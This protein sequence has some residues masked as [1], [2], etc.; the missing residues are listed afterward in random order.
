MYMAE[1]T[2]VY[3]IKYRV[4]RLDKKRYLLFP[5]SLV[6]GKDTEAGFQTDR[7]LYSYASTEDDY[8]NK[9]IVDNVFAQDE[10][11]FIYEYEGDE[12]FLG[13]YFFDDHKDTIIYVD[14]NDKDEW[15]SRRD[16]NLNT[17]CNKEE[18]SF[19]MDDTL[20]A[21]V[22][23]EQALKEIAD[24]NDLNEV[25]LLIK[26]YK[27]LLSSFAKNNIEKGV[28]K[29]SV[30]N[31]KV[32][33]VETNQRI[34]KVPKDIKV[35][36]KENKKKSTDQGITYVGL[37]NYLKERIYGHDEE[38]ETIALKL[39]M[40]YTAV[41]GEKVD[42]FLIVGP[43]GTGKT[44][45]IKA[46]S[47]YLGLPFAETNSSNLVPQGIVGTSIED[48]LMELYT[49]AGKDL[50]KAER[51]IIF[52]DEFDKVKEGDGEVKG[53]V[54]NILL[55]FTAGGTFP[56]YKDDI[57]FNTAMLNKVY[58]GVFERIQSRTKQVGF[59]ASIKKIEPLGSEEEIRKK[60]IEKGYFTLEELSR[61]SRVLAYDDLDRETKKRILLNSK[62]SEFA[63]RKSRYKR[64]FDVDLIADMT[65]I[66]AIINSIEEGNTG[67]RSVNNIVARTIDTAEKKLAEL[68][69]K[70]FKKLIVT[71]DTVEDPKKFILK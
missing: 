8:K 51:G 10:L 59:N 11:E 31:G 64:Q 57:T 42:S 48:I 21:V 16:V 37:R 7:T 69:G 25:K 34:I 41:E 6:K 47:T 61:I 54:K 2:L 26:K 55:T 28:T 17:L 65:Y 15:K 38:I 43:T 63:T 9:Y 13:D 40:N 66:D 33:T 70:D 68:E 18:I 3:G 53:P 20:P 24:S 5:V 32:D 12:D 1:S 36:V 56:L 14:A 30:V 22:F 23:N 52:L 4:I 45:T 46:A 44:E 62:L 19:L 49:S 39:Y 27:K 35:K 71:S 60:I 58:A 50:K 67:M 29:I